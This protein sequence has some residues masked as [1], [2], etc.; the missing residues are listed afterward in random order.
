MSMSN[1]FE[2]ITKTLMSGVGKLSS[3]QAQGT[4]KQMMD[5]LRDWG[6]L[7]QS[8]AQA[9]QAVTVETVE[10]FKNVKEPLAALE[11]VKSHVQRS[12]ALTTKHLQETTALS[13]EQFNTGVDLLQERHPT[14]DAFSPVAQ[15]MKRAASAIESGLLAA[16]NASVEATGMTQATKK[17]R[18]K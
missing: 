10:E 8:Q 17:S 3:D 11:A 2:A 5:G 16:L 14:P 15:G 6:D 12:I 4:A 18:S 1:Q 7:V 13:I 9:I